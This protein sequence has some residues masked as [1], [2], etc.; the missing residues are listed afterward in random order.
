MRAKLGLITIVAAVAVGAAACG[1][2]GEGGSAT[3]GESAATLV[4]ESALAF[5]TID[6]DLESDQIQSA[7]DVL[8]K[9]PIRERVLAEIRRGLSE[10]GVNADALRRSAGPELDIAVL[11]ATGEL[12]AAF[13]QPR[14]ED[15]FIRLLESG[16][17][18]SKHVEKDGWIVFSDEQAALDA[19]LAVGDDDPKLADAEPFEQA[20]AELP[21]EAIAKVYASRRG[22]RTA[23]SAGGVGALGA[24]PGGI[25]SARW[26]SG[27]LFAHDDGFEVQVHVAGSTLA[28]TPYAGTLTDSIPADS[29]LALSFRDAG[30]TLNQ[31]S[32]STTPFLPMIEQTLGVSIA[33]VAAALSGEGVLYVRPGA[34]IPEVTLVTKPNDVQ[35]AATTI[36]RLVKNVA[37]AGAQPAPMTV[38]GVPMQRLTLGPVAILYGVVDG[39]LVVTDNPTAVRDLRDGGRD[40]LSDD[41]TF[42]AARDAAGMPDET[43]GWL[44]VNLKDAVPLVEGLA[45]LGG[46][47]VPAEVSANLRPLR[48]AI[49]FGASDDDVE[50]VK[51]FVNTS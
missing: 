23:L 9:F 49:V 15:E 16:D 35:R 38:E 32:T 22:I 2:G 50:T 11:G 24:A 48:S 8:K 21:E 25:D 46:Q 14:D 10:E 44:Y 31:L 33:D 34:G 43:N 12:V 7:D 40:A 3:G 39:K 47:Q 20:T 4:S 36:D 17:E 42:Q 37:P 45:G 27:A 51:V 30:R 19:I 6:T 41:S 29:V 26:A 5:V 1:G 13:T 28:G 18:P